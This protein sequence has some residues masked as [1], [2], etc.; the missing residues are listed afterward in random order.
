MVVDFFVFY[1][2]SSFLNLMNNHYLEM[3]AKL[4]NASR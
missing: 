4:F 2:N 1:Y 3:F